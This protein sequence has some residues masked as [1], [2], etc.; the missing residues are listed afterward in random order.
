M[1]TELE[2]DLKIVRDELKNLR[3]AVRAMAGMDDKSLVSVTS[4][5]MRKACNCRGWECTRTVPFPGEPDHIAFEVYT[6]GAIISRTTMDGSVRVPCDST[7]ADYPTRVREWAETMAQRHGDVTPTE[8][9][10]EALYW[11]HD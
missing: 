10:A 6:H 1:D 2:I 5:G 7:T 9:L 8:I 4:V 11:G 3:R